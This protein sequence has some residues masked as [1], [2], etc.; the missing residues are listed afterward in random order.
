MIGRPP[1]FQHKGNGVQEALLPE[2]EGV[3]GLYNLFRLL[4]EQFLQ[5]GVQILIIVIKRI[6][7]HTAPV[8][9]VL[10]GDFI[11][12]LLLQHGKEGLLDSFFGP[13][14]HRLTRPPG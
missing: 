12:R 10:D 5:K 9:Q 11:Q 1:V 14:C 4:L 8:H 3:V 13:L 6:A 2:V 7:V